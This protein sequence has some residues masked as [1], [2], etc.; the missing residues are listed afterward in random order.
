MIRRSWF[1]GLGIAALAAFAA[2]TVYGVASWAL[3]QVAPSI[4]FDANNR[5]RIA[6]DVQ[7][8]AAALGTQH[9]SRTQ[10]AQAIVER[11][12]STSGYTAAVVDDNGTLLAGNSTLAGARPP[13]MRPPADMPPPPGARSARPGEFRGFIY[14]M[15]PPFTP[16]T[17]FFRWPFGGV[18]SPSSIVHID[19]A[20]VIFAPPRDALAAVQSLERRTVAVVVAITFLL[21]WFLTARLFGGALRPLERLRGGLLRLAHGDYARIETFSPQDEVATEL[22]EAYNAAAAQA[23]TTATHQ[24]ELETNIRQF[25]ADAGHELRTPLAVI[26]GY[27]QLLRQSGQT[28]DA[29]TGRVFNEID[30]QGKRM[31]TL[32]Q[33]L[34]LLT[35]LESQEPADVKI[36]DAADVAKSVVESFRP[37]ANGSTLET[38]V[39]GDSFVQVSESELH[40][41]IGNLLDNAIKYAPGATVRTRVRSKDDDVYITVSDDGPGM[42]PDVRARAFERFSRGETGG[43]VSGSGLGLAIVERALERAGG[44]VSLETQ[45]GKGTTVELRLPAWHHLSQN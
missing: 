18:D 6:D 37:L 15:H 33:K 8:T 23:E 24:R 11:I 9:R 36:L 5:A 29:L 21:V 1:A 38:D 4:W 34:L 39:Q 28:H 45:L 31:S 40:E 26:M 2:F 20:F 41:A 13:R 22:A 10:I 16:N 12:D 43:S 30:D 17:T 19:G 3:S 7:H 32:I 44:S 25:V 35:R 14:G 42:S 27:V